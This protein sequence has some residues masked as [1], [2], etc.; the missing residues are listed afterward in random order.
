[1]S[2]DSLDIVKRMTNLVIKVKVLIKENLSLKKELNRAS[3]ALEEF[4]KAVDNGDI[5]I[6]EEDK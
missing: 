6:K 2:V 1:M 4:Q 3:T 5:K